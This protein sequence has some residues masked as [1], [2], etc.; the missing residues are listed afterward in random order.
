M[1]PRKPARLRVYD[2]DPSIPRAV[3]RGQPPARTP[4]RP[5]LQ[6]QTD[7]LVALLKGYRCA[8]GTAGRRAATEGGPYQT[9]AVGMVALPPPVAARHPP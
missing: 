6:R 3:G 2:P 7:G 1:R 4:R 8:A 5:Q 9:R